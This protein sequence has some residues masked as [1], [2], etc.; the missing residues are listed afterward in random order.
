VLGAPQADQGRPPAPVLLFGSINVDG[1]SAESGT[2]VKAYADGTWCGSTTTKGNTYSL[3]VPSVNLSPERQ[4]ECLQR[5]ITLALKVD[6]VPARPTVSLDPE[7]GLV[8]LNLQAEP[9]CVSLTPTWNNIAYLGPDMAIQEALEPIMD[10]LVSVFRFDNDSKEWQWF[11]AGVPIEA[12]TLKEL[13][14]NDAIWVRVKAEAQW[15]W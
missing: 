14:E 15:C 10:A 8:Q 9:P 1:R 13:K 4:E 5:G 11:L 6:G 3:V 2:R 7:A 12:S